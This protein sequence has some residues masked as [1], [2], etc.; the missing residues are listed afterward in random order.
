MHSPQG[1]KAHESLKAFNAERKLSTRHA[2][3]RGKTSISQTLKMLPAR[4]FGSVDNPQIL[5]SSALDGR[6]QKPSLTVNDKVH[7][8]YNHPFPTFCGHVLP[9]PDDVRGGGGVVQFHGPKGRS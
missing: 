7:G 2:P 9:P 1:L 3:L 6:L 5:G 4:I 8:L